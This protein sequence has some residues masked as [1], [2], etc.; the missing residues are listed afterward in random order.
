[1]PLER[2]FQL[3]TDLAPIATLQLQNLFE[4]W[5]RGGNFKTL[6]IVLKL[7]LEGMYDQRI[8]GQPYNSFRGLISEKS[9]NFDAD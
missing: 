1:M 4:S 3:Q 2:T 9:Q 8:I 5:G 7:K 6:S